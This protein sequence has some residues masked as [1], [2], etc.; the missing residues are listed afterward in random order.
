MFQS[1]Q[2]DTTLMVNKA[3]EVSTLDIGDIV[4]GIVW[5]VKLIA[6]FRISALHTSRFTNIV[7]LLF[8]DLFESTLAKGNCPPL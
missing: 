6:P 4:G 3:A 8:H 7:R 5:K 1:N 2:I